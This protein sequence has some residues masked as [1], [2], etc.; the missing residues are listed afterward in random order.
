MA[1]SEALGALGGGLAVRRS[2]PVLARI[3][4]ELLWVGA[5]LGVLSVLGGCVWLASSR[6]TAFSVAPLEAEVWP[7]CLA[8]TDGGRVLISGD[9]MGR[10]IFWDP[11]T[12]HRRATWRAF[13]ARV[14]SV[15]ELD[16]GLVSFGEGLGGAWTMSR[17]TL[18]GK[19]AVFRGWVVDPYH[20]VAVSPAGTLF[21]TANGTSVEISSG[22]RQGGDVVV[23]PKHNYPVGCLAFSPDNGMLVSG[24]D[25]FDRHG[26]PFCA[27]R[28]WKAPGFASTWVGSTHQDGVISV[29][30]SPDGSLLVTGDRGGLAVVW[31][32]AT[33]SERLR[34][35]PFPELPHHG[36]SNLAI[37]DEK[38]AVA[39][40]WNAHAGPGALSYWDV[41]TGE[42]L[43]WEPRR[44][45]Q[46]ITAFAV[47][48]ATRQIA[49][50]SLEELIVSALPDDL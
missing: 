34:V 42:R 48:L 12:A 50:G 47:S 44:H 26:A 43:R 36:L 35:R 33:G 21:A 7:T 49:T 16:G 25:R 37:L 14:S 41:R 28:A 31:D 6:W 45:A 27:V 46:S 24:E 38:L 22:Q 18:D 1:V 15:V 4:A 20:A 23:L 39:T 19:S 3:N 9:D 40:T 30:F 11:G 29:A 17:F 10:V 2:A 13:H 8:F 5:L 32:V